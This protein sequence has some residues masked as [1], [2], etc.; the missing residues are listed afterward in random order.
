MSTLMMR[1]GYPL[2]LVAKISTYHSERNHFIGAVA[3]GNVSRALEIAT[4]QKA[5]F[6]EDPYGRRI[7][8]EGIDEIILEEGGDPY[9]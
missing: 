6:E 2:A 9:G 1:A 7:L 8:R 4:E 3:S 5:A